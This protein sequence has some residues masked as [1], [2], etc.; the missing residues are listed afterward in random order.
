MALF[1]WLLTGVTALG[2]NER[3]AYEA[4]GRPQAVL[5]PG[6]HLHWPWPF[7]VLR[8]VDFGRV[9]SIDIEFA[10]DHAMPAQ[11]PTETQSGADIGRMES[12]AP[13]TADRLWDSS[14]PEEASYLVASFANGRQG[15][16]VVDIDLSVLYRI[17]LSDAAAQQAAYNIVSPDAIIR[18][19]TGQILVR[20]FARTTITDILGQNRETFIRRFQKELQSRL[21]GLSSGIEIMGVVVEAIHPPPK[22]A[23]AYQGVQA[24]G[25]EAAVKVATAA[26]ESA[27]EMKM[28]QLVANTTR[29]DAMGA[30]AER[31]DQ[32]KTDFTLFDG[33]RQAYG[34]GGASFLFERRLDRLDKGLADKP[35]IIVDHRIPASAAPTINMLP[36]GAFGGGNL[37]P[38]DD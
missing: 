22:A 14:H 16:E 5:H 35:L 18:A 13:P 8:P 38:S 32:A 19:T 25:I 6:L 15:F 29:N 17:G 33:D 34:V 7:G 20:Y 27:R 37:A 11:M 36:R 31:I 26:A 4:F 21:A 1:T 24:A 12:E 2:L 10:P 30:A 3:A 28:A 23:A 9:R